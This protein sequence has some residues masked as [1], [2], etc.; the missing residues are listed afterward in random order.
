M[1]SGTVSPSSLTAR[2]LTL[3]LI[4][5]ASERGLWGASASACSAGVPGSSAPLDVTP[6]VTA[7]CVRSPT[8][9]NPLP[10]A[11]GA[12]GMALPRNLQSCAQRHPPTD[13]QREQGERDQKE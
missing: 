2:S 13:G 1:S 12:N 9:R 8:Q 7:R 11:F 5:R 4:A 6:H 3:T 10:L